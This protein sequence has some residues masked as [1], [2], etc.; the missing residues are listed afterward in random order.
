MDEGSLDNESLHDS[1]AAAHRLI[2][3]RTQEAQDY[4]REFNVGRLGEVVWH[5]ILDDAI[6]MR[7]IINPNLLVGSEHGRPRNS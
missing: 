5:I 6:R 2:S 7:K 3:T 1:H 4:C